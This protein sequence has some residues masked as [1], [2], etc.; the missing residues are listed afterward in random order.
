MKKLIQIETKLA[1]LVQ[2]FGVD[3]CLHFLVGFAFVLIFLLYGVAFGKAPAGWG[4]WATF[5][6]VGLSY[7]K[8]KFIDEKFDFADVLATFFGAVLGMLLYI[9]IDIFKI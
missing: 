5:V 4:G 1:G 2:K 3:K 6:I 9:P 8:E 7:I